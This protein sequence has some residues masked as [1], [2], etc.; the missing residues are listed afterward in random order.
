MKILLMLGGQFYPYD[1]CGRILSDCLTKAVGVEVAATRDP[2]RFTRLAGFDAVVIYAQGGRLTPAQEKG[3]TSFVRGGGGL[4]GIHSAA[5]AYKENKAYVEMIGSQLAGCGPV[6]EFSV[7]HAD[8][9]ET[10]LP[11]MEKAWTVCDEF[12][13][14][15]MRARGTVRP[16]QYGWW[17]GQRKMLG[18]VRDY[19]KG[20]VLYTALGHD[21][22][23]FRHAE[24][25]NLLLKAVRYVTRATDGEKPLRWGIVGYGPACG[26]GSHHASQVKA[27]PQMELVA[28]CDPNP[29]RLA[30]ARKEQGEALAYAADGRELI[31]GKLCDGV[32]VIVPHHLHAEVALPF[33]EAGLHVISEKPFAITP[34]ECDRMIAASRKTGAV[35]SVYHQ[36]HWDGDMWTIRQI[37]ESGAIGEVFSIEHNILYYGGHGQGWRA[38]K[39]I[40]GG[41]LYDFGSHGFEKIFQLVP[42][43][44]AAGGPINRRAVLFGN[45]LKKVWHDGTNEDHARAYV[46]FDT[47]LEAEMTQSRIS[48]AGKPRWVVCGTKGSCVYTGGAIEVK[49]YVNGAFRTTTVPEVKGLNYLNYYR[50]FA[51]HVYSG[52]PLII[53]PGL[54]KAVIQ[55]IH[56]CE[57]ASRENRLVEVAFDFD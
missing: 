25:Q 53:T 32:T 19:G 46:K 8:D 24:F 12:Y 5:A 56:G 48:T 55:C 34:E 14:L 51:D 11:R 40:S 54:A 29:D 27:T 47:A 15:A 9:Y 44:D 50:N 30:I 36:R 3:L 22:A 21:E 52:V 39:R 7:E 26:M 35:L 28:V 17:H 45:F 16:F 57:I 38:D 6:A 31:E 23:T 2:K 49:Q 41:L 10:I 37:V 18:Y 20:R 1:A 42:K 13:E 43:A 4:V 33:L